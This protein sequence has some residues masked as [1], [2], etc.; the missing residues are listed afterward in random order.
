MRRIDWS[1]TD[2]VFLPA[3]QPVALVYDAGDLLVIQKGAGQ[4]DTVIRMPLGS[5]PQLM[6]GFQK[7]LQ[8]VAEQATEAARAK[9]GK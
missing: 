5:I 1:K 6:Q 2:D 3:V 7:I 4:K 8:T 9:N